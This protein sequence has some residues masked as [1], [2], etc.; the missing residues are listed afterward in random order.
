[1]ST[2]RATPP[3]SVL[4]NIPDAINK[5]L[6]KI[7]CNESV[8][9]S[10]IP[11]YQEALEKSGY[12][13]KLIFDPQAG[14]IK[15]KSKNRKRKICWFNPPFNLNTKTNIGQIFLQ[16]VEKSF[17]PWHPLKKICNRNTIKLSYRCTP[18]MSSVISARN[19]KLLAPPPAQE[20]KMCSCTGANTC[21][22]GG[23]CLSESVV[24]KATVKQENLKTNTY[25][26]LTCNT[27]KKRLYSHKQSFKNPDH[28]QTS[29]SNH[30]RNLKQKNIQHTIEWEQVDQA[31]PFS[32]ISGICGLCTKEK[33]YITF[34]PGIGPLNKKSEMFSNCRHKKRVLLCGTKTPTDP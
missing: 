14:K 31:K 13:H 30:I 33:F 24:Y 16:L 26:G 27:F 11:A 22:L 25:I 7:S 19:A 32:P 9:N 29:L 8:F 5:R 28:K 23:K 15:T 17:P 18:S 12:K 21:P 2:A 6:S 3:P 10:A 34:K 4:K 1:M 20:R